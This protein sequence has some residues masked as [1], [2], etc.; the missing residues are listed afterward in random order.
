MKPTNSKLLLSLD[1]NAHWWLNQTKDNA[2][3]VFFEKGSWWIVRSSK[4]TEKPAEKPTTFLKKPKDSK[5][6]VY[7][8]WLVVLISAVLGVSLALNLL[9][10]LVLAL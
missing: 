9:T 8:Q 4:P 10:F 5:P 2:D 6:V 1:R 3:F 7:G